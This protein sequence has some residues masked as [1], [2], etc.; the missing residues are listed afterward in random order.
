MLSTA[1]LAKSLSSSFLRWLTSWHCLRRESTSPDEK[2]IA[3]DSCC[4]LN[5]RWIWCKRR[6]GCENSVNYPV[7]GKKN[8][9]RSWFF[10]DPGLLFQNRCCNPVINAGSRAKHLYI[11]QEF[12]SSLSSYDR[13]LRGSSKLCSET[14]VRSC[15]PP[16]YSAKIYNIIAASDFDSIILA[17]IALRRRILPP[18]FIRSPLWY[19]TNNVSQ[20][21][22]GL[23]SER[24]THP[25][26]DNVIVVYDHRHPEKLCVL[27]SAAEMSRSQRN[28]SD[29][30][31]YILNQ[32][33]LQKPSW[34]LSSR[35]YPWCP[36][37]RQ[38]PRSPT[39]G[40]T[41]QK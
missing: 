13:T 16:A 6:T 37:L 28:V 9:V 15:N 36:A 5:T 19:I 27:V 26:S 18:L 14:V 11:F 7:P 2:R 17:Y 22:I 20:S 25:Y 34:L 40:T 23:E 24:Y 33:S 1:I 39:D 35:Q 10:I 21:G 30:C 12:R 38:I 41:C 31:S 32:K 4:H 3:I 29:R 8:W